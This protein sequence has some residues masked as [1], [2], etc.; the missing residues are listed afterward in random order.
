MSLARMSP[1][2]MSPAIMSPTTMSP[3][4]PET[5]KVLCRTWTEGWRS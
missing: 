2:T 3:G 4:D 5:T 1:A